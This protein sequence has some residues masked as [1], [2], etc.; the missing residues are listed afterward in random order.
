MQAQEN[1]SINDDN[2]LLLLRIVPACSLLMGNGA[3]L[4]VFATRRY[5]TLISA[6][7]NH[8]FIIDIRG[9]LGAVVL[10]AAST[11]TSLG[12]VASAEMERKEQKNEINCSLKI[13]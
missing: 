2:N 3:F 1:E 12:L 4:L 11:V 8:K 5:L 13:P 9:T 10:T 7:Q 6:L